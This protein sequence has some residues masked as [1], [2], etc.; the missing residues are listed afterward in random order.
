MQGKK[1]LR[2]KIT[3]S[4]LIC[5]IDDFAI[6]PKI[7]KEI[8]RP[9]H[10]NENDGDAIHIFQ[11]EYNENFLKISF[12]SGSAMPR[13]PNVYNIVE[14]D[15]E[16]NPRSTNQVEPRENFAI[17]DLS[18]SY[19]WISDTRKKKLVIDFFQKLFKGKKLAI[20]DVYDKDE[21]IKT[22]KTL[23]QIKI[24][25]A[26]EMFSSTHTLSK[27]LTDEMYGACEAILE[28]KYKSQHIGAN[29]LDKIKNIF[30]AQ[31]SFKGVMIAGRDQN[32][33]GVLFNNSLFSRKIDIDAIIDENKMFDTQDV[34]S[35]II[36]KVEQERN[37]NS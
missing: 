9:G 15:F 32:N 8:V 23:D 3:F 7:F 35:Q 10:Y 12:A 33:L 34:F 17:F 1:I 31:E 6:K 5:Y 36:T 2:K 21:F 26:P 22:I 25:A 16:P 20:K 11:L 29:L 13:N 27:A 30:N 24:S 14:Q 18:C 4:G 37:A 28:L 19:L